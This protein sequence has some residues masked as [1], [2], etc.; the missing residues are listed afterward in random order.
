[1]ANEQPKPFS[2]N[3]SG[4]SNLGFAAAPSLTKESKGPKFDFSPSDKELMVS[5]LQKRLGTLIGRPSGYLAKLPECMKKRVKALKHLHHLVVENEKNFQREFNELK[6]KYETL[7][8]PI[9]SRR[10][11]L[12]TGSSEPSEEELKAAE[13]EEAA[14]KKAKEEEEEEAKKLQEKGSGEEGGE[15]PPPAKEEDSAVSK[16]AQP[17]EKDPEDSLPVFGEDTKGI[18]EFWLQVISNHPMLQE[19]LEGEHDED[20]LKYLVD[21]SCTSIEGEPESFNLIFSFSENPYFTNNTLSKTYHL[22][23]EDFN[24]PMLDHITGTEIEW[25]SGKNLTV[26]IVKKK[27]KQQQKKKRGRRGG[28]GGNKP[29]VKTVDVEVACPTFFTFF[30]APQEPTEDLDDEDD[31]DE[32][33]YKP[34]PGEQFEQML[35]MDYELGATIRDKVIQH[36]I[37]YYTGEAL[38]DE[39]FLDEDDEEE[40]DEEDGEDEEGGEERKSA[41]EQLGQEY[42]SDEDEDYDPKKDAK[43]KEAPQECKQS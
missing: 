24:E 29:E 25:K 12:I 30:S 4:V 34:S 15:Q 3:F 14:E 18:P 41:H 6:K 23:D 21:I 42:H 5:K 2:F 13:D 40:E 27:V 28:K 43:A 38:L 10:G 17:K 33:E 8:K 26:K 11:D 9:F 22:T 19:M 35:E 37:R 20:A 39:E 36:A 7:A 32:D 1:M 31:E 16:E